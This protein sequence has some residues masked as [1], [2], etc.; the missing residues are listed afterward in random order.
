M[1]KHSVK[2]IFQSGSSTYITARTARRLQDSCKVSIVSKSPFVLKMK[3]G[4][5]EFAQ[6][7]SVSGGMLMNGAVLMKS[8][9]SP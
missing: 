6:W 3:E 4:A 1:A 2:L 7:S 9:P 5:M 8:T